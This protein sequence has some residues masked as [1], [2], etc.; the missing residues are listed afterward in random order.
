MNRRTAIF[1]L[2]LLALAIGA[3]ATYGLLPKSY[4][5]REQMSQTIVFW[6]D[7]EAFLFMNLSTTGRSGNALQE[8]LA[9][10]RYGFWLVLLN[11]SGSFYK[12]DTSAYHLVASGKLDRFTLPE[13][14]VSFGSWGLR[15][16][17]LQLTPP[18]SRDITGNGF[19]WDGVKFVPVSPVVQEPG[20]STTS[21][22]TPDDQSDDDNDDR[23]LPKA[24]RAAFKNA[25]WHYK[26]LTGYPDR[27][28]LSQTAA[29]LPLSLDKNAFNL[30]V[31]SMPLPSKDVVV[32]DPMP[33]GIR[34]LE[35]SGTGL[36]TEVL[37]KQEGWK[38]ISKNEYQQLSQEYGHETAWGGRMLLWLLVIGGLLVWKFAAWGHLLFTFGTM[39]KRVLNNMATSYSFPPATPAQFPSLDL[40]TLD[41]YTRE[42][43][44]M[45]FTYL[46][47]FSLVA[48]R[49][50]HPASFCRLMA[51]TGRHCFAEINQVFPA[52]KPALP[53]KCS[54]QSCL[55]DGWTI[56]FSNRKPLAASN[57]L[58]RAKAIGVS[59]PD[60]NTAKLLQS[61]LRMRDQVT[62]DL[63]VSV[64]TD[65]TLEAYIQKTQ[66]AAQDMRQAVQKKNFGVRIP[67]YYFRKLALQKTKPEY[68]WLGD[69]PKE[70]E[71]R[72]QGYSLANAH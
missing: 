15:D 10:P 61:F 17:K 53:L 18:N 45:G 50:N 72:R 29:T 22:L 36:A 13:R 51:H 1:I 41:R 46:T 19:R 69:Y 59:M 7:R 66:R 57:F 23:F 26:V 40:N 27:E 43:E 38:E 25:G 37:W 14:T 64:K 16:G 49:G 4:K 31:R 63:G 68:V 42:F 33:L 12:A 21:Q 24:E 65:D 56:G 28:N 11:S 6:N 55:Q 30:T 60:V 2:A 39:K 3:I 71:Q 5:I 35:L 34:S 67:Q 8:K 62:M 20:K 9:N 47:D 48:D 54:I 52:G 58:R 44:S 70:A 32:V